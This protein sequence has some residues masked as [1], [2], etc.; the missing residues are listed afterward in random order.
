MKKELNDNGGLTQLILL[1]SS[2][3]YFIN[4]SKNEFPAVSGAGNCER[5]ALQ[6]VVVVQHILQPSIVELENFWPT[7]EV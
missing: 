1:K 5:L 4:Y 3:N 6:E 2:G 7:E